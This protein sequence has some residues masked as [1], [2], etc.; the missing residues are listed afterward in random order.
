M[1]PIAY[2]KDIYQMGYV[3][4]DLDEAIAFLREKTGAA[5]FALREPDLLVD[6]RGTPQRLHMRVAIANVGRMQVEVIQPID[7]P[8]ADIYREGITLDAGPVIFH[9]VGIAIH[10]GIANWTQL[11]K[12]VAAHDP[13]VLGF[14]YDHEGAPAVRFAYCDTRPTLGHY[15]EYLWFAQGMAAANA[16][17]PDLAQ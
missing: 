10:G 2:F 14:A 8:A 12:D 3:T 9:H 7:G 15:T 11:E 17:L 13:F 4:R 6:W 16:A 5:E 1:S